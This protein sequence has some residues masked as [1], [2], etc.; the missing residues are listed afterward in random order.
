[1]TICIHNTWLEVAGN[2]EISIKDHHRL[3]RILPEMTNPTAQYPLQLF[4]LGKKSKDQALRQVFRHN[5]FTRGCQDG[6]ANLRIDT[7]TIGIDSPILFADSDLATRSSTPQE[8][9]KCHNVTSH[10]LRWPLPSHRNLHDLIYVKIFFSFTDVICIF[11]DDVGG[12]E[13]VTSYLKEWASIGAALRG[14]KQVRPRVLIVTEEDIVSPTLEVLEI[15]DM[16]F[17]LRHPHIS[18]IHESFSVISKLRLAGNHLSLQA[19]YREL[20]EVLLRQAREM[21]QVRIDNRVLYSAI[22]LSSLFHRAVQHAAS[23]LRYPFN[24]ILESR[25]QNALSDEYSGYL[26]IFLQLSIRLKMPFDA[27]AYYIGSTILMDAYPPG[28]HSQ[29]AGAEGVSKR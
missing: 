25:K 29:S 16:K 14:S 10:S 4:F 15:E 6:V 5:K 24:P 12:L 11:A 9:P 28:M 20:R 21:R 2:K 26:K 8:P 3:D 1:M 22:H 23:T 19:R 7:S 18:N 17:N 13:G 27:M